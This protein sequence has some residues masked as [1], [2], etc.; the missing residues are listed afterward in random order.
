M[1]SKPL[2]TG[3][4]LAQ[5]GSASVATAIAAMRQTNRSAAL[6]LSDIKPSAVTDVTGY[7]L[8][9]HAL[10]MAQRSGLTVRIRAAR[11][12]ALPGALAAA[13]AGACTSADAR[14]RAACVGQVRAEPQVPKRLMRLLY[15]PQTSGGLLAAVHPGDVVELEGRGFTAIGRMESGSAEVVVD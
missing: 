7:G 4:L 2:G 6:A 10:E 8:A 15:D 12:P 1:L 9:G 13:S 14:T 5:G 3:L 11:A